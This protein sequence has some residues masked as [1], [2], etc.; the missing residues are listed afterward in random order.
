MNPPPERSVLM[1]ST[2]R[3]VIFDMDG[4]LI[5]SEPVYL[6]MQARNLQ[7]KYPWVT[8]EHVPH[9]GHVQPGVSPLYG[10]ALPG[11]LYPGV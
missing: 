8:G 9:R 2:I 7:T 1:P 4:V 6:G 3:A 5:D 11:A 10:Q